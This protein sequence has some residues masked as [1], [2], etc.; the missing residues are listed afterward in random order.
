ML[1]RK[2]D[3]LEA[4]NAEAQELLE[5][6]RTAPYQDAVQSLAQLRSQ[7]VSSALQTARSLPGTATIM[8]PPRQ[9]LSY[10]LNGIS[11][12]HAPD[13]VD[14]SVG[15]NNLAAVYPDPDDMTAGPSWNTPIDP[16]VCQVYIINMLPLQVP[17]ADKRTRQFLSHPSQSGEQFFAVQ[18]C[19]KNAQ[20]TAPVAEAGAES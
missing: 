19:H 5:R 9:R 1:K 16:Y 6:L 2:F 17:L 8:S 7:N 20:L 11:A 10:S 18:S 4:Q 3:A 14:A 15:S 13:P 12:Q